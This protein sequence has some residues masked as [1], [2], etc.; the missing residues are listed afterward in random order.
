MKIETYIYL[1]NEDKFVS[2][3]EKE[4]IKDFISRK[5]DFMEDGFLNLE[6]TITFKNGEK[7]KLSILMHQM[8]FHH[9]GIII[10]ML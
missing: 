3:N 7:E 9:F 8:K 6:G 10:K 2:L 5:E 1:E 4:R